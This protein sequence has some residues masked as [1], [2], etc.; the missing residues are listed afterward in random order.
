[1]LVGFFLI[2]WWREKKHYI[3]W[4]ALESQ[5][6]Q[7]K[8]MKEEKNERAKRRSKVMCRSGMR[9]AG[10]RYARLRDVIGCG[11]D[12][13]S[14]G[15]FGTCQSDF[16]LNPASLAIWFPSPQEIQSNKL[17][18]MKEAVRGG[19]LTTAR[20]NTASSKGKERKLW[21]AGWGIWKAQKSKA[22]HC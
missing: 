18:S 9:A 17:E 13:P 2:G 19:H 10:L 20:K 3:N 14:G 4:Q 15:S 7:T 12:E 21:H 5:Y 22:S 11:L 1:M 16:T 6:Y 8:D